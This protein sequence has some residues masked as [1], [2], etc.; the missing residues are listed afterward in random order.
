M[1]WIAAGR[2]GVLVAVLV[3]WGVLSALAALR[4]SRHT[5]EQAVWLCLWSESMRADQSGQ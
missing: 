5:P 4:R 2:A 1:Q 3:C